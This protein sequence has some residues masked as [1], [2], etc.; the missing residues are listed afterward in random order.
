MTRLALIVAAVAGIAVGPAVAQDRA[1]EQRAA[2]AAMAGPRAAEA[3]TAIDG[4]RLP[5]VASRLQ[6]E[7]GH[8]LEQTNLRLERLDAEGLVVAD[9]TGSATFTLDVNTGGPILRF[10]S[11]SRAVEQTLQ[12]TL[13]ARSRAERPAAPRRQ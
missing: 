9:S 11:G 13:L 1:A 6:L 3:A 7:L 2:A 8:L 10:T 4:I 12:K 5:W